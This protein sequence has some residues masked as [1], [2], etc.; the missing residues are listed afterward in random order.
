MPSYP[1]EPDKLLTAATLLVPTQPGRGRP[2]YTAHRRGV[3]T[4]YYAVF[5]AISD[6]AARQVFATADDNFRDGVRRWIAHGDIRT[7][8]TWVG[9]LDGTIGGGCPAHI[10]ALLAPGGVAAI[11]AETSAIA[12]GFLELHEKR[13]QADYDHRAVFTRPDTLGHLALARQV[14]G[15]VGA[16][17]SDESRLFFGLVAM[18]ARVTPR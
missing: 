8:A 14:I 1:I 3:S 17:D 12:E 16:V 9:K 13:E 4:A 15:L 18:Q 6:R 11:D 7:V 10:T 5:H 2:S